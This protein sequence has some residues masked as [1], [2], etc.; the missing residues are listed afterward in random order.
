MEQSESSP[1]S[2]VRA[3]QKV[4]VGEISFPLFASFIIRSIG[5]GLF[6]LKDPRIAKYRVNRLG[7]NSYNDL[8]LLLD[9]V[10]RVQPPLYKNYTRYKCDRYTFA[11][12]LSGLIRVNRLFEDVG[13]RNKELFDQSRTLLSGIYGRNVWTTLLHL[14]RQHDGELC[15]P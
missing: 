10:H 14:M 13:R 11:G 12:T 6:P 1:L 9:R 3:M 5:E 15:G 8:M 2:L 4:T 7:G